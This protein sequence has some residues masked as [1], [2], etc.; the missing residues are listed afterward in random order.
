MTIGWLVFVLQKFYG[1]PAALRPPCKSI[2]PESSWVT[3]PFTA[4]NA[5]NG[6]YCL[7]QKRTKG[8]ASRERRERENCLIDWTWKVS[9]LSIVFPSSPS[10]LPSSR[11]IKLSRTERTAHLWLLP[12]I[13]IA[14]WKVE[15][16]TNRQCRQQESKKKTSTWGLAWKSLEEVGK[17]TNNVQFFVRF[18]MD[19]KIAKAKWFRH[20][21]SNGKIA[22]ARVSPTDVTELFV[23]LAHLTRGWAKR[24]LE[25]QVWKIMRGGWRIPRHKR[26]KL[27]AITDSVFRHVDECEGRVR[28]RCEKTKKNSDRKPHWSRASANNRVRW[29]LARHR[30]SDSL[31]KPFRAARSLTFGNDFPSGWV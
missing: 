7:G 23:F 17:H 25:V 22:S 26:W 29:N 10:L 27:F 24:W 13:S 4:F 9:E 12:S 31:L 21:Y 18:L 28:R 11:Q 6:V 8:E 19:W 3:S 14:R 16:E 2:F 1:F 5:C 15:R 20:N 30:G